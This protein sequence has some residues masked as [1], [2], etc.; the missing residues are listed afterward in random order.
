MES[1][2]QDRAQARAEAEGAELSAEIRQPKGDIS[3]AAGR[4]ERSS[5]LFFGTGDNPSLF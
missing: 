5:P 4:M 2:D 1:A 3:E